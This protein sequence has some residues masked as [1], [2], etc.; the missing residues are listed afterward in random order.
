MTTERYICPTG[1]SS[2]QNGDDLK[3]T[4]CI[5]IGSIRVSCPERLLDL[6]AVTRSASWRL[7]WSEASQHTWGLPSDMLEA[8]TV[9][10][11]IDLLKDL[12]LV[13]DDCVFLDRL[14]YGEATSQDHVVIVFR[15]SEGIEYNGPSKLVNRERPHSSNHAI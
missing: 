3:Q 11:L 15:D 12:S 4:G 2:S 7:G 10:A 14:G 5:I 6:R 1:L 13:Q 9:A 8:D